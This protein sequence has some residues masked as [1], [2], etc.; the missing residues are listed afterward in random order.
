MKIFWKLLSRIYCNLVVA[1]LQIDPPPILFNKPKQKFTEKYVVRILADETFTP[2]ER[3]Y[4][5]SGI[6][7]LTK[8][9][10]GMITFDIIFTLD[11]YDEFNIQDSILLRVKSNHQSIVESDEKIKNTT[12]GLYK[13]IDKHISI[14]YLV[15]DRLNGPVVFRTTV[16]HELGHFLGL[17]H[18]I[19]E[20][21]MHRSNFGHVLYPTYQDAVEFAKVYNC[22]P[23]DLIYFKL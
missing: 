6:E 9:C 19:R 20:S 17:H 5:L 14:I 10:N 7:D 3:S 12:L 2:I 16:I 13:Y 23:E 8:F 1:G 15:H 22:N 11:Y 21:I 18:T 4:I